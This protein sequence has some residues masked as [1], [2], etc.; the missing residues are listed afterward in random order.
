MKN[1]ETK[2]KFKQDIATLEYY[3]RKKTA[4]KEYALFYVMMI[5]NTKFK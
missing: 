5:G 3:L 2:M 4:L 1:L